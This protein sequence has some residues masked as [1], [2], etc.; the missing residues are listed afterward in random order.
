M[1]MTWAKSAKELRKHGD[2]CSTL[3]SHFDSVFQRKDGHEP[4]VLKAQKQ[5]FKNMLNGRLS[6]HFL[7]SSASN[8]ISRHTNSDVPV[9]EPSFEGQIQISEALR[10]CDHYAS[11]GQFLRSE[12][13]GESAV[14]P[15]ANAR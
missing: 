15:T 11:T 8:F 1:N 14:A 6:K 9:P 2:V 3:A 7:P 12:Y 5:N 10:T 4:D 13:K